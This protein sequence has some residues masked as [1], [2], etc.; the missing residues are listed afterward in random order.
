MKFLGSSKDVRHALEHWAHPQLLIVAS[1]YFWRSGT[2]LQRSQNPN[3]ALISATLL[4]IRVLPKQETNLDL[5]ILHYLRYCQ[6]REGV[7][8]RAQL[9]AMDDLVKALTVQRSEKLC[10]LSKQICLASL[11]HHVDYL[12]KKGSKEGIEG[13]D[14]PT[15]IVRIIE[16]M[17][18]L[19]IPILHYRYYLPTLTN[20][21]IHI[22]KALLTYSARNPSEYK[23]GRRYAWVAITRQH[24]HLTQDRRWIDS[25]S[26]L[27]TIM[28]LLAVVDFF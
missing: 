4:T 15:I 18:T 8:H 9:Q 3:I 5:L 24:K 27:D 10:K 28:A 12:L 2:D 17:I 26:E 22:V 14:I 19:P 7:T 11:S 21:Y 13:M 23:A 1:F 6:L 25:Y 20:E 16:A